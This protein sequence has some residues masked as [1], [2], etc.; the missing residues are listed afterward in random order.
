MLLISSDLDLPLLTV[1]SKTLNCLD[2]VPG[3]EMEAGRLSQQDDKLVEL[4]T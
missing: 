4:E 3:M 1:L 2:L